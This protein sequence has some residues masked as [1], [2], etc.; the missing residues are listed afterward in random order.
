[1]GRKMVCNLEENIVF[2]ICLICQFKFKDS[3]IVDWIVQK[4]FRELEKQ[5][6]WVGIQLEGINIEE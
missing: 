4:V 2:D 6:R 3:V 5:Q 1:M